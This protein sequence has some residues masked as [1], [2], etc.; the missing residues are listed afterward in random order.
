MARDQMSRREHGIALVIVLWVVVLL[1]II[2]SSFVYNARGH[3]QLTGNLMSRARAQALADAGL[4]R[5]M[6]ELF[7]PASDGERWKAEGRPYEFELGEG[8]LT[9]TLVDEAAYI[10]LNAAQDTLL[11]GLLMASGVEEGAAQVLLDAILDWRDPDDL[12]RPSG[13]ERDQYA[14]AGL[15]YVPANADFRSVDE[16]KSVLGMTPELYDRLS[17]ALTVHS[18]A[19]GIN[20]SLAPAQVLMAIPG[21]NPVDVESYLVTRQEDL[22]AGLTPAPFPPAAA[23]PGG[24]TGVYNARSLAS[25][26]DGTVFVREA[27]ARLTGDPKRPIAFLDW[28]EGRP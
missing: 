4:H 3:I 17:G 28:R 19:A 16:L 1:T 9:V 13:A 27:V 25:L 21:V 10:D 5:G 11:L 18:R 7:K 8:K 12:I 24:G 2:V 6:Y 22:A 14:A 23:F 26:P 15:A 20:A